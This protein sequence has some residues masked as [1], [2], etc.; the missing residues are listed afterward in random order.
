MQQLTKALADLWRPPLR[1]P[2][3]AWANDHRVLGSTSAIPGPWETKRT[4][5]LREIMDCL[6]PTSRVERVSLMFG[7]QLGKS[8]VGNNTVG[9]Y[10]DRDPAPMLCAQ[11]TDRDLKDYVRQRL[12]PMLRDSPALAAKVSEPK[13]RD[14]DNT[15]QGFSFPGGFLRTVTANSASAL[16]STPVRILFLDEIDGYPDDVDGEGD[17]VELAIKRTSTFARRKILL[18]STPTIKGES[19]IEQEYLA[20]DR[21]KYWVPCPHCGEFQTLEWANVEWPKGRPRE[22]VYVCEHNG[23]VI[24]NHHKLTMLPCGEWRAE[25]PGA[26]G[27]KVRGFHL[28]GLYAPHGLGVTFG[29]IAQ[30]FYTAKRE[31]DVEKLKTCINTRFAQTWDVTDGGGIDEGALLE[32]REKWNVPVKL[33]GKG[34][35]VPDGAS[36]LTAGVDVQG[37]RIE[38]EVV[39]WGRNFES[40][41]VDYR[42]IFGD[43]TGKT[44]WQDLDELLR[45]KY[46]HE[47]GAI[48][49]LAATCIDT[50]GED[51]DHTYAYVRPRQ[52]RRVWGVK[53]KEGDRAIWPPKPSKNNKGRIDLR[54]VGIDAAKKHIYDR[55]NIAEPGPGY[56][57]F[58]LERNADYFSQL[59]AEVYERK[60]VKGRRKLL[61]RLRAANARNEALDCRVYAYAA[62]M[63]WLA[64]GKTVERAE[65][66]LADKMPVDSPRASGHS[67]KRAKPVPAPSTWVDVNNFW[68]P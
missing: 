15:L 63:G 4:S 27:G 68:G 22:A 62:L 12:R 47:S 10:V 52:K 64:M 40:W 26:Q 53:G 20:S 45:R 32:L 18:T 38:L 42:V 24:E 66:S 56:C 25:R 9:Y 43:P 17:P 19:R 1:Q 5:Y 61:W 39:G 8:E 14:G 41:S 46:R 7:V 11:P 65:R 59:T 44:V 16:R 54:I 31:H 3:W 30:E 67:K 36:V 35:F 28:N 51:T 57:H 49:R 29:E 6:S 13:S 55:L 2:V 23:C 33:E 48:L 34:V 37:N 21:C 60:W 58:P 50:G